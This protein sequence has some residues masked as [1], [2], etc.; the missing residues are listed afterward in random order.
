MGLWARASRSSFDGA[1][2]TARA[3]PGTERRAFVTQQPARL[4]WR[5]VGTPRRLVFGAIRSPSSAC[6]QL[7]LEGVAKVI[8]GFAQG[9]LRLANSLFRRAFHAQPVVSAGLA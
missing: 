7:A 5:A 6:R 4:Q 1:A 2:V 3:G 8:L 9:I